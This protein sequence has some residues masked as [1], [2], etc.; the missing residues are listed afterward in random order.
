M[1]QHRRFKSINFILWVSFLAFAAFILILTW[2]F[3]ITLLRTFLNVQVKDELESFGRE[4]YQ[5]LERMSPQS[6]QVIDGYILSKENDNRATDIFILDM[7]GNQLH[8]SS[9]GQLVTGVDFEKVNEKLAESSYGDSVI[10]QISGSS[11][12]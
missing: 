11:Y 10:V 9:D 7:K 6:S 1:R 8:P 4:I 5:T 2:V 3:Q 12:G